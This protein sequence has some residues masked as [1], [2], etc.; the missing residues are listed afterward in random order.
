MPDYNGIVVDSQTFS[1]FVR[2][3][4]SMMELSGI[5]HAVSIRKY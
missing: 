4:V 5:F 2:I 3:R 1:K